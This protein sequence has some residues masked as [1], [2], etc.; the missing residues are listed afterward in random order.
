M[1]PNPDTQFK[2]GVSGNP[3]GRRLG[4]RNRQTIV[5]EV[6]E[7]LDEAT[8]LPNVDA[9]TYAVALKAKSGDVQAYKELMDG[10]FGKTADNLNIE[11]PKGTMSPPLSR[12]AEFV[13][14]KK[15]DA[16]QA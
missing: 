2:P 8:G 3:S 14:R 16:N 4:S 5:R 7:A 10:G 11:S 12:L 9:M 13:S 6:L 15:A 1:F